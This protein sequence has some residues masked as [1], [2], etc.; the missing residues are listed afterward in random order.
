MSKMSFFKLIILP[1]IIGLPIVISISLIIINGLNNPIL[2]YLW[3]SLSYLT[4]QFSKNYSNQRFFQT[5]ILALLLTPIV[6]F[7]R[8]IGKGKEGAPIGNVMGCPDCGTIVS[9]IVLKC[10][11]CGYEFPKT[12]SRLDWQA[13]VITINAE[14]LEYN[15]NFI[16]SI[17]TTN[18]EK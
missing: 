1:W 6:Q 17:N 13:E 2:S 18:I 5:I 12:Q 10:R 4:A 15:E 9:T 14:I 8:I 11:C 3:I 7:A 16:E